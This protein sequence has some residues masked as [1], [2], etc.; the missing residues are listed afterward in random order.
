MTFTP[1]KNVEVL[2]IGAGIVGAGAFR[3]CAFH[4]LDTLLVDS[5]DF[6]DRT[7]ASSSKL[8]HGGIRYLENLDF[9]LVF[10]AL[11]E[12]KLWVKLAP[13]LNFNQE[14]V[15]PLYHDS[16]R[17]PFEI[18]IGI[19]LYDLLAKNPFRGPKWYDKKRVQRVLPELKRN[20]LKGAGVYLDAIMD[21]RKLGL[22]IIFEA[23]KLN[24][25]QAI[26]HLKLIN[27]QRINSNKIIAILKDQITNEVHEVET[28]QLLFSTGPFI[29]QMMEETK[30]DNWEKI[31]LASKGSHI[32][33]HNFINLDRAVV[34]T[35][36]DGRIIFII[37]REKNRLLIGTTEIAAP[38]DF[39]HLTI[40]DQETEY[41]IN[42]FNEYFPDHPISED[43]IIGS[44]AGVR[45]LV[46]SGPD[47]LGKT[48][49]THLTYSLYNNVHAIAGG[50]Y[51]TFRVMAKELIRP[52]LNQLRIPY[53]EQHSFRSVQKQSQFYAS[54]EI[55][56][57]DQNIK[58]VLNQEYVRT[59]KDYFNRIGISDFW[60]F[61]YQKAESFL[62]N[63]DI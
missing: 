49:R 60:N 54:E 9:Q 14:F 24:N 32:V 2:I 58:N 18:Q 56:M 29:D 27:Y 47:N 46:K 6:C 44:Y 36:K 15:M 52:M 50:K 11:K 43:Q 39:D 33:A 31:I 13:H 59:K 21:D 5:N 34:M 62:N 7:S 63:W 53:Q 26:N 37:P 10:E 61:D 28:K 20:D 51:T 42:N 4:G 45:P 55:I 48:A 40:S 1:K 25:A 3:E 19:A 35:P 12:K 23:A 22:E 57:N 30:N 41:L 16:I 38:N 17:R 8:L